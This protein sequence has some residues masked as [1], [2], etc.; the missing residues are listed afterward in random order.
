MPSRRAILEKHRWLPLVLPLVVFMLVGSLEPRPAPRT[1]SGP[2]QASWMVLP[3]VPYSAYPWVYMAK[4]VLSSATLAVVWPGFREFPFR[5]S[6]AAIE[7]GVIGVVIW[8]VLCQLDLESSLLKGVGLGW[9]LQTGARSAF[10]PLAQLRASPAWA[11][12]FLAVRFF[13]LAVVAPLAEEA[14]LRGFVMRFLVAPE[15]WKV[16]FGRVNA[17]ALVAGTAIPVL[18]HPSGEWLA[19]AVW[20]SMVTGL[21]LRTKNFWDCVAAHATTNLLLG[22]Y[23][24]S[25]GQWQLL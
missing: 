4:I 2:P 13:G 18:M 9:L 19:A 24:V 22:L 17:V 1:E 11:W 3:S 10:D 23:V 12:G 15:W 6:A 21:M 25:S 14:F 8:I 20:F 7:V 5:I 16:P